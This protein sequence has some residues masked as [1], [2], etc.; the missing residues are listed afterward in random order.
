M[1]AM[2]NRCATLGNS[3]VF[4]FAT[5]HRP[6]PSLAVDR[7]TLII[8]APFDATDSG[9]KYGSI[10]I[11]RLKFNNAP[12]VVNPM[13]DQIAQRDSLFTFAVPPGTFDD[14]D[15]ADVLIY[16]ATTAPSGALPV[17]LSFDPIT[18]TFSGTPGASNVG[19]VS[20]AVKV[21]ERTRAEVRLET[22]SVDSSDPETSFENSGSVP[23]R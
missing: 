6:V 18:R 14:P 11:F 3:S 5:N 23:H 13:L 20:I 1:L 12:M 22:P 4:A 7:N 10:Y 9:T 8:G 17:W 2:L 19:P 21:T 16:S 15:V